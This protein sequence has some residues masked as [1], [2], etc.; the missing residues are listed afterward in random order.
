[1]AVIH[2]KDV[3]FEIPTRDMAGMLLMLRGSDV[4]IRAPRGIS[5]RVHVCDLYLTPLPH[6]STGLQH[7]AEASVRKWPCAE[8]LLCAGLRA[9]CW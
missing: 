7:P 5:P 1:M 9:P 2:P 6:V 8:H 3:F 4:L